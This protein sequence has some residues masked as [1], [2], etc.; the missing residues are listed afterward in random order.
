MWDN[1]F[2]L[3][4][5]IEEEGLFI[6]YDSNI[7]N[8]SDI[9]NI[10][11]GIL[12]IQCIN[13]EQEHIIS[14]KIDSVI[15]ILKVII[16]TDQMCYFLES[17]E[18]TNSSI[19]EEK[20]KEYQKYE[21]NCKIFIK[22][23]ENNYL[24]D[25]SIEFTLNI[26]KNVNDLIKESKNYPL[27]EDIEIHPKQE[28]QLVFN[29]RDLK[30]DKSN[31]LYKVSG[32]LIERSNKLYEVVFSEEHLD[33]N[34]LKENDE[35][36]NSNIF[37]R[38]VINVV[39]AQYSS[40]LCK[41]LAESGIESLH[42][43]KIGLSNHIVFVKNEKGFNKYNKDGS[44]K[45]LYNIITPEVISSV[46]SNLIKLV[47]NK[48]AEQIKFI[49]SSKCTGNMIPVF[50]DIFNNISKE[51]I[52]DDE[53]IFL[54][55]QFL[56]F[57]FHLFF[58][59][60]AESD[61][62]F[63]FSNSSI[64]TS[65][66]NYVIDLSNEQSVKL[67]QFLQFI[68]K[69][70]YFSTTEINNFLLKQSKDF[71]DPNYYKKL[72]DILDYNIEQQVNLLIKNNNKV[73]IYYLSVLAQR[74]HIYFMRE[75]VKASNQIVSYLKSQKD[76][77]TKDLLYKSFYDEYPNRTRRSKIDSILNGG[78]SEFEK[79]VKKN[80][81]SKKVKPI[82]EIEAPITGT[83]MAIYNNSYVEQV[84]GST[85]I[86]PKHCVNKDN[87]KKGDALRLEYIFKYNEDIIFGSQIETS[88]SKILE[89]PLL[90][91]G[92]EYN[93]SFMYLNSKVQHDIKK[94]PKFLDVKIDKSR[95]M[96]GNYF[97]YK[98]KYIAVITKVIDFFHYEAK[99]IRTADN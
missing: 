32:Q 45:E 12:N 40:P 35:D 82:I 81:T 85:I 50:R 10:P 84:K 30:D 18:K 6:L 27:K 7:I 57:D 13:N 70:R 24:A 71:N 56:K 60:I 31:E 55:K 15:I 62:Q 99:L 23:F 88:L 65:F 91:I 20:Y 80:Q 75:H 98:L 49:L 36:R 48:D 28:E 87:C 74:E 68:Y 29:N 97:K 96:R 72:F 17:I 73:S 58:L 22:P 16:D 42:H 2:N 5:S 26:I 93:V 3:P 14:F 53:Y 37:Y 94:I 51:D 79:I 63:D 47:R 54:S 8:D 95:F 76:S 33:I 1:I 67:H 39:H 43:I 64:I 34:Y 9:T 92:E 83:I 11:K 19:F 69:F 38:D 66:V 21:T 46:Y 86:V 25:K 59:P 52:S 44:I 89:K 4:V 41:F 90:K 61:Y 77:I 78:F